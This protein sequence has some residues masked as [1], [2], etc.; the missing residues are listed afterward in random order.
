MSDA[1][2]SIR[3][4]E[5]CLSPALFG[6][7]T[8]A[9]PEAHAVKLY[10]DGFQFYQNTFWYDLGTAPRNVFERAIQELAA[11]ARPSDAV[12]GVE[13]WFSVVLNNLSP[14]WLIEPH[15]DR[16]DL[17]EKQFGR[18]THPAQSSVLF[19]HDAPYGELAITDQTLEGQGPSPRL[20]QD[21][22]CIL[23]TANRYAVFPG[24]LS[25][26]VL[27]RLWRPKAPAALRMTFAVNFWEDFPGLGQM[28]AS[29]KDLAVLRLGA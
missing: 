24:T 2:D 10:K 21:M 12:V 16:D 27:G 14:L 6:E 23:P 3:T 15:F 20:P 26:G 29:C 25:H 5:N 1:T 17:S 28:K 4:I 22:R 8:A 13:W 18:V 19:L 9:F 11:H 7:L